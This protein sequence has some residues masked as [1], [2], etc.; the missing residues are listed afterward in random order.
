MAILQM[1]TSLLPALGRG[2]LPL[3]GRK[4]VRRHA[5]HRLMGWNAKGV[6]SGDSRLVSLSLQSQ[7]HGCDVRQ[8]KKELFAGNCQGDRTPSA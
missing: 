1:R 4:N 6:C 7:S 3:S 8:D 5:R 2:S